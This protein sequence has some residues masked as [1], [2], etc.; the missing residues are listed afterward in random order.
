MNENEQKSLDVYRLKFEA[1]ASLFNDFQANDFIRLLKN[2]NLLEEAIHVGNTFLQECPELKG[3]INQYGYAL[4]NRDIAIDEMVISE[5]EEKFFTTVRQI[6]SLCKAE[7]YS[8]FD[9]TVNKVIRYITSKSTVN[10]SLLVNILEYLVPKELSDVSFMN[11]QGKEFE[12][13]KE[14]YY[15]LYTRALFETKDYQK[16]VEIANHALATS[17]KWHYNAMQWIMYYRGCS[18][19]QLGQYQEAEREF[20]SLQNRIRG[21]N[22]HDVLYTTYASLQD[23]KKANMYLLYEFFESGF[24]ISFIELYKKVL[25]SVKQTNNESLI[26]V[27]DMFINAL[28]KENNLAYC[29]I[30]E[31]DTTKSASDLYDV[32]Y[33]KVMS[34]LHLLVERKEGIVVHYN[35]TKFIGTIADDFDEEGIFFRQGDYVYD[36]EVQRK[37]KVEYTEMPT[38]DTKKQRVTSKAILIITTDQYINFDF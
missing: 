15:R 34:N 33:G 36:E 31:Y 13:K 7:K 19:V 14:R 25:T 21:I 16:C 32:L 6:L 11:D 24:D 35:K 12:S 3:Y 29:P 26:D 37:D 30:K 4:Y 9:A 27:A 20:L 10:Y 38:F 1:G 2:E 28:C 18:L 5:N 8:P 23:Y 22:F 17:I